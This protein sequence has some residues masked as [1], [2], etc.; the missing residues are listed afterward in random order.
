MALKKVVIFIVLSIGVLF[1]VC[2][3]SSG[4]AIFDFSVQYSKQTLNPKPGT[5]DPSRNNPVPLGGYT[6][7]CDPVTFSFEAGDGDSK[8]PAWYNVG[9]VGVLEAHVGEGDVLVLRLTDK[10]YKIRRVI[11]SQNSSSK[12]WGGFGFVP[13]NGIWKTAS[14]IWTAS[15]DSPCK[16]L[17][18]TSKNISHFSKLTVSYDVDDEYSSVADMSYNDRSE[19]DEVYY[20][21]QGFRLNGRPTV[22]GFYIVRSGNRA[23][24]VWVQ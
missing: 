2:A 16:E 12:T 20:T 6:F 11:F 5:K 24:K 14:L 8:F 18:M 13:D 4:T 10:R 1:N 19:C 9:G 3:Q 17:I 7:T 22:S 21:V 23:S 15:T